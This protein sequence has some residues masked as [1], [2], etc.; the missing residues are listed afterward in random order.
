MANHHGD[1]DDRPPRGTLFLHED[2]VARTLAYEKDLV[3]WRVAE[4][5]AGR[6]DPGRPEYQAVSGRLCHSVSYLIRHPGIW[7]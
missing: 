6:G 2:V 4:L 1:I 7:W 5:K 3:E